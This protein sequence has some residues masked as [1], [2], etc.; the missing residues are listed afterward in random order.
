LSSVPDGLAAV[1]R[2]AVETAERAAREARPGMTEIELRDR[3]EE[4]L[5]EAG[6]PQVWSITNVGFGER[7][8]ICFPD[9]PPTDNVLGP[10]DVGH[11]DLHPVS[12]E[13]W[14][15]DCT[16][17]FSLGG[18]P[19]HERALAAVRRIHEETLA[20]CRPGMQARELF[21]GCL[22]AIEAAGYRLLDPWSN[23][24]HSLRQGSAY[25]DKFIDAGN[26]RELWGA[27]AVEPFLGTD[28]F[29]VKLEDVVWFGD[30]GCVVLR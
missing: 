14:W 18:D 20:R 23:I 3:V 10:R 2:V 16:R 15:G 21:A 1:Q 5:R 6:C 11:V 8:T 4:W 30:G 12:A 28:R 22:A 7:S 24:G 13:G 9:Q 19:E 25:D 26:E 17:T 27:W 29:G